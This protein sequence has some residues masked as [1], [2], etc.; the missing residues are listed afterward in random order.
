MNTF[1]HNPRTF[2][3]SKVQ[4]PPLPLLGIYI[5]CSLCLEHSYFTLLAFT[6]FSVLNLNVFVSYKGGGFPRLLCC[7]THALYM[8]SRRVTVWEE[9]LVIFDCSDYLNSLFSLL[10]YGARTASVLFTALVQVLAHSKNIGWL[11]EWATSPLDMRN[12]KMPM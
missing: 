11:T 5:C 7:V 9:Y 4:G 10:H 2:S 1:S 8:P 3:S 6:W 12:Q